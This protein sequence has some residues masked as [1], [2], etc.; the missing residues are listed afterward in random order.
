MTSYTTDRF[1]FTV[2]SNFEMMKIIQRHFIRE[3]LIWSWLLG[4]K[5]FLIFTID[6]FFYCRHS[7][8]YQLITS[9]N[10]WYNWTSY[11]FKHIPD[12]IV[13]DMFKKIRRK[14]LIF[15][16]LWTLNA[17]HLYAQNFSENLQYWYNNDCSISLIMYN[18]DLQIGMHLVKIASTSFCVDWLIHPDET[19]H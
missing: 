2:D 9:A 8:D 11:F 6:D 5:F 4:T 7:I 19:H 16:L 3:F 13:W 17:V 18:F 12:N 15:I 10:T 1:V 14:F